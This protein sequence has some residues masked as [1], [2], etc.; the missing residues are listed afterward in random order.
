MIAAY[1]WLMDPDGN[2]T[3][4]D[5]VPDVISCSVMEYAYNWCWD[6]EATSLLDNLQ[7]GGTA[8]IWSVGNCGGENN[9]PN[10]I[11]YRA[12][13]LTNSFSVGNANTELN[14]GCPCQMVESS[15]HGPG[16][17]VVPPGFEIKPEVAAPGREVCSSFPSGRYIRTSGTSQATPH[18]AGVIALMRQA[19]PDIEVDTMLEILMETARDLGIPGDDNESGWGL[20]DAERAVLLAQSHHLVRA[21]GSG[22]F[23]NI[24]AAINAASDGWIID[25]A[26]GRFTGS[27]NHDINFLGKAVVVRSLNGAGSCVIGAEQPQ[28]SGFVFNHQEGN[29]SV[30][31]GVTIEGFF[32]TSSAPPL[33]GGISIQG[34]SPTIRNCVFTSNNNAINAGAGAPVFENCSFSHNNSLWTEGSAALLNNTDCEMRDCVFEFNN[35]SPEN[36]TASIVTWLGSL[37]LTRCR[38]HEN[39]EANAF[40]IGG[41]IEAKYGS[42]IATDCIFEENLARE[43]GAIGWYSSPGTSLTLTRCTF[44]HNTCAAGGSAI[45]VRGYSGGGIATLDH[46]VL[47]FGLPGVPAFRCTD[48]TTPPTLIC[49]DVFGNGTDYTPGCLSGAWN[50]NGNFSLDPLYCPESLTLQPDSPCAMGNSPCGHVGALPVG[51]PTQ[52]GAC[53]ISAESCEVASQGQCIGRWFRGV[54][55]SPNPCPGGWSAVEGHPS[56]GQAGITAIVP[57]PASGTARIRYQL[58]GGG[59]SRIEIFNSGGQLVRRLG[60]GPLGIGMHEAYWDAR[61]ETRD[62]V[63]T[64]VYFVRITQGAWRRAA[65]LVIVR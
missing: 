46:C 43:G 28:V 37:R 30:L 21:D 31:D 15:C 19:N 48:M 6:S 23:P 51:C 22:E 18:V 60:D 59:E 17:C 10:P 41:A 55:C 38:F 58:A 29:D 8:V 56:A 27:G 62:L 2:P 13:T 45:E 61:D 26:D 47:S 40:H 7:A 49:C 65:P 54:A 5:D 3:T 63:P 53:C 25:L 39:G 11:A 34:C 12:S 52:W 9:G 20:I 32:H 64:G 35:Y 1:Q 16:W 24:Q 44:D 57:N 50:A 42:V 4:T 14:C 36:A 33:T